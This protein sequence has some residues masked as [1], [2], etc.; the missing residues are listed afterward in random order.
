MKSQSL[1]E[2]M[3][4]GG[5][6]NFSA[7]GVLCVHKMVGRW[8]ESKGKGQMLKGSIGHAREFMLGP[9]PGFISWY[10]VVG[11]LFSLKSTK[12]YKF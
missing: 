12:F 7:S 10:P 4:R 11:P 9:W 5:W 3:K 6:E 2:K 1:L 8:A